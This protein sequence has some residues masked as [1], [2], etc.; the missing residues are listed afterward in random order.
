[1]WEYTWDS[2]K[3]TI[4]KIFWPNAERVS[5]YILEYNSVSWVFTLS[6]FVW[7]L[8]TQWPDHSGKYVGDKYYKKLNSDLNFWPRKLK[9]DVEIND[10]L[11]KFEAR[12]LE[13]VLQ[14]QTDTKEKTKKIWAIINKNLNNLDSQ[15]S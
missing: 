4:R 2:P 9:N 11:Q 12:K 14:L 5:D 6:G 8:E 10:F 13:Q 1:M 3:L 7:E 15:V